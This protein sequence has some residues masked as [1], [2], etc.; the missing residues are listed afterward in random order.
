MDDLMSSRSSLA[1]KAGEKMLDKD[2]GKDTAC[3][4]LT[5]KVRFG[6]FLGF[7]IFGK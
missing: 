1:A 2:V 4:S 7:F 6:C 3:P 5:F